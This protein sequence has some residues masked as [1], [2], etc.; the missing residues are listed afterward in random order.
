[1]VIINGNFFNENNIIRWNFKGNFTDIICTVLNGTT[2][3]NTSE[4]DILISQVGIHYS[5]FVLPQS[6]NLVTQIRGIA[7]IN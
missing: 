5:C 2:E 6:G 1:M 4:N 7:K 3:Y